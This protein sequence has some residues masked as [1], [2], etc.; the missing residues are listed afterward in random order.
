MLRAIGNRAVEYRW[1]DWLVATLLAGGHALL[2]WRTNSFDV[3]RTTGF[4]NRL[5]LYTDMIT[6]AGL[7]FGFAAT[8]LATYLAFQGQQINTFRAPVGGKVL[9]QW[10]S[11]LVGLLLT[12]IVLV[13]SR[14][15]P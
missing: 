13:G 5:S 15:G 2:S 8:A 3:L 7:L 6:V 10:M 1:L 14:R 9:A 11:T 4:A 12:L